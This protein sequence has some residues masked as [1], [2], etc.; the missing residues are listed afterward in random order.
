[1][2]ARGWHV[3]NLDELNQALTEARAVKEQVC[4]IECEVEK[5]RYGPDSEV[6]WDV[7]PAEVTE[8]SETLA[9]R[10]EYETDRFN[11]QKFYY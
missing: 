7:A 1:M 10:E 4:L 11:K 3:T 8:T 5:H 2:G 6:W 9:A